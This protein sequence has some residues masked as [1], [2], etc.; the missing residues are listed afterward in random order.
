M[1]VD[2]LPICD[3]LF[4]IAS[5]MT[6]FCDIAFNVILIYLLEKEDGFQLW[7]VL[8]ALAL[9]TSILL[10]QMFS[11]KWYIDQEWSL[12]HR[13][14]KWSAIILVHMAMSAMFWRYSRL[15]FLPIDMDV[16]K[17][18]M[19]NLSLLRMIHAFVHSVF[20][21]FILGYLSASDQISAIQHEVVYCAMAT[22]L[23]NICWALASFNKNIKKSD[24]HK[25]ILTWIGVI[26]Q[27]LWRAG[28]VTSRMFALVVYTTVHG[29][30][31]CLFLVLHW[32]C[33]FIWLVLQQRSLRDR[34]WSRADWLKCSVLAYV[35]EVDFV[36]LDAD[37][38]KLKMG[39]YYLIILIENTLLYVI[40]SFNVRTRLLFSS[41]EIRNA[42]LLTL[43]PHLGGLSVMLLYYQ[44]FHVSLSRD[45]DSRDCERS[46]AKGLKEG[47][48]A[49]V[50]NCSLYSTGVAMTKKK[51]IPRVIPPPPIPQREGEGPMPKPFWKMPL[52]NH[53]PEG[54]ANLPDLPASAVPDSLGYDN[55]HP[56]SN[57]RSFI[58]DS[59][60]DQADTESGLEHDMLYNYSKR[61]TKRKARCTRETPIYDVDLVYPDFGPGLGSGPRSSEWLN[62]GYFGHFVGGRERKLG[63]NGI[64]AKNF[65]TR[66]TVEE[67][68]IS[69][70]ASSSFASSGLPSCGSLKFNSIPNRP[71]QKPRFDSQVLKINVD[72][73]TQNVPSMADEREAI[74]ARIKDQGDKVR[75]LKEEKAAKEMILAE[76]EKLKALKLELG[77]ESATPTKFTLK[78]AKGTRDYQPTQMAI[79]ENV[80]NKVTQVFKLH[81]AE[82]IDTPVF[83]LKIL[84]GIFEVCGVAQDMFRTIC[85]SV[86]KLDKATWEEVR[87]EMI[88]EKNLDPSAAD[89]IGE[90]VQ[91]SGGLELV[92]KLE[93]TPLG[94]NK[95][96]K[97]GLD[98]MK[99][100]L[101]Y[102]DLY[103]C[104]ENV[105][106]DLSLA[107]GLDYYT[108]V[109]YEAVLIGDARDEKGEEIQVGSVAGGGRYDK[110]VGMFDSKK[111]DV[112]CVGVSIGI[113]RLFSIMEANLSKTKVRTTE[114]QVYVTTAQKNLHEERL[115]ICRELWDQDIKTENPY[116]K[117]PKMLS[118]LQYCEEKGIPLAVI[119]GESELQKGVV[120]VRV[121]ETRE[122]SE[123]PRGDLPTFIREKLKSMGGN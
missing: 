34:T 56:S 46:S 91:M 27:F 22:S 36:H 4:N 12:E 18:E 104:L 85:S 119:V 10:C 105:S 11:L 51:K 49:T 70:S 2:F 82:T 45:K 42:L 80:L 117:N 86:D 41:E 97:E 114:T 24:L 113:E 92:D 52:P 53:S 76:V 8:L 44:V 88:D 25:L 30:W 7:F 6:Y 69:A 74:L 89:K 90:F 23:V 64:M 102:C 99:Q 123:V 66:P 29:A 39:M 78:T 50:F 21:I 62:A 77:E 72:I 60:G 38:A 109:I 95:T 65:P 93:G 75:K 67:K 55:F 59:S 9:A 5:V 103:G 58:Y 17:R 118:Q 20:T 35:Y 115:K 101:K 98:G 87:K 1:A 57:E 81:G 79:R 108:G 120:K 84:D 121:V 28:T 83:E 14:C 71:S 107:R 68:L 110:L 112:P 37:S 13:S 47:G 106:F 33:M 43:L 116:K 40:W 63:G 94:Q 111:R 96:A 61:S 31:V 100:L 122:E 54:H 15:L 73:Q 26:L 48:N 16:V 32:A 3:L 19:R